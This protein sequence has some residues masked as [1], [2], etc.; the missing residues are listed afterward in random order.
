MNSTYQLLRDIYEYHHVSS[1]TTTD[2]A[3]STD[4]TLCWR[5]RHCASA[6]WLRGP[7]SAVSADEALQFCRSTAHAA[8]P[9]WLG[10]RR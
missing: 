6:L 7:N 9:L 8:D 2:T 10:W 3:Y 5:S 4:I 1:C